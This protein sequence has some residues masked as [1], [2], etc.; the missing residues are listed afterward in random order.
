MKY[1]IKTLLFHV[2]Y[3][4]TFYAKD[5]PILTKTVRLIKVLLCV[6]VKTFLVCRTL[7][8]CPAT[9]LCGLENQLGNKFCYY[10][11]YA[12]PLLRRKRTR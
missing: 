5:F 9:S 6:E 2:T 4:A 12:C 10:T 8:I 11:N 1:L 3:I 7:S